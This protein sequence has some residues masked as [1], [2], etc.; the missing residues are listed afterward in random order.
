MAERYKRLYALPENLYTS[1]SPILIQAVALLKDT[2]TGKI[3]AQ[4]K[5][6]NLFH[7]TVK[8]RIRKE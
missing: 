7:K 6:K 8:R 3:L 5:L 2:Q 1:G 4:L